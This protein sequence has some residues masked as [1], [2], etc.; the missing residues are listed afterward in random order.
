[1]ERLVIITRSA[2]RRILDGVFDEISYIDRKL[3]M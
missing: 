2:G 1:M 3:S